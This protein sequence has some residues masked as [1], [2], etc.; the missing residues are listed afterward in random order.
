VLEILNF[1]RNATELSFH[2]WSRA[3]SLCNCCKL[4]IIQIRDS[5][6][7]K[8]GNPISEWD[9]CLLCRYKNSL[10]IDVGTKYTSYKIF[11]GKLRGLKDLNFCYVCFTSVQNLSPSL[12]SAPCK[13]GLLNYYMRRRNSIPEQVPIVYKGWEIYIRFREKTQQQFQTFGPFFR[14]F[15]EEKIIC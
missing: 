10:S 5:K 12:F 3:A 1:Q 6:P 4:H 7:Q 9:K 13:T 11:S 15:T 14:D 8:T 2:V